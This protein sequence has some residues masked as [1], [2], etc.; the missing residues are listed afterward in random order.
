MLNLGKLIAHADFESMVQIPVMMFKTK[1][2]LINA[3]SIEENAKEIEILL[4]LLKSDIQ[5]SLQC[6]NQLEDK[7]SVQKKD[8]FMNRIPELTS[9]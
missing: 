5:K 4:Y 7:S 2:E 3:K 1:I 9:N 8:D 6:I